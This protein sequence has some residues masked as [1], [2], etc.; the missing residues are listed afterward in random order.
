M[1]TVR[2]PDADAQWLVAPS[3]LC[4]RAKWQSWAVLLAKGKALEQIHTESNSN[5]Y[6]LQG[7]SEQVTLFCKLRFS[8]LQR[9]LYNTYLINCCD[10][11]SFR[12]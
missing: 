12:L 10:K 3:V 2:H 11:I 4:P 9:K 5:L 7:N 8:Y 6:S 1:L